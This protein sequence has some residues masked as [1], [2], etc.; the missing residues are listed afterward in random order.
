MQEMSKHD[1]I[2]LE[3]GDIN[4]LEYVADQLSGE[5]TPSTAE[6]KNYAEALRG[7]V[8]VATELENL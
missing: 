1:V 6:L 8:R 3:R 5:S 2:C 7:I 4:Y